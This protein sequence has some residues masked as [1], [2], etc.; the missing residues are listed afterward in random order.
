MSDK[1]D[2]KEWTADER[3]KAIY[4]IAQRGRVS[5]IGKAIAALAYFLNSNLDNLRRAGL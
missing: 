4:D 5:D 3:L 2:E 1:H